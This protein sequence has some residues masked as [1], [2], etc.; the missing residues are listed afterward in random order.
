MSSLATS[1]RLVLPYFAAWIPLAAVLA[2]MLQR[3]PQ[4]TWI[5]AMALAIP[6]AAIY[7][8]VCLATRYPVR[9]LP[10]DRTPASRLLMAH[11]TGA[12]FAT[13]L[14]LGVL[15]LWAELL[16]NIRSLEPLPAA[17]REQAP[18]L[19]GV[20]LLLYLLSVTFFSMLH[21]VERSREAE[22][23]ALEL[24]LVARESELTLLRSQVDPHFLFNALNAIAGLTHSD[25]D[26]ARTLCLRLGEFLRASLR[27]GKQ[28]RIR[29][30]E[31]LGFARD[32][33]GIEQIRFGPRLRVE[34]RVDEDCLES[35][36]PPLILQPLLENAVRHGVA[37]LVEGGDVTLTA[38]L[39]GSTLA[40]LVENALDPD[41][42]LR[43]G[44]GIGL[45]N[46]RRRLLKLYGRAGAVA[47]RR[48][49]DR[50]R[51]ELV[52]P[53]QVTDP[54]GGTRAHVG[55]QS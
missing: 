37:G 9:G 55:H 30:A 16:G 27:I 49:P 48:E 33:L 50:F 18:L 45:A 44:E 11:L 4:T 46:V 21:A 22:R 35:L 52:I 12:V 39:T 54:A 47:V 31:E 2:A 32:F 42:P 13:A 28:E 24:G 23:R 10:A 1:R 53:A 29:F 14:W 26:L 8:F 41:A 15:R 43:R 5:G 40:V 36:V 7:A 20:G 3:A 19:A 51:V 17:F 38:R 6:A 25:P 34:E